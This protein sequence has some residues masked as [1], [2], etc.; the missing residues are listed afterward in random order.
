M[1]REQALQLA[2][3][4]AQRRRRLCQRRRL[5]DRA[6]QQVDRRQHRRIPRPVA[7]HRRHLLRCLGVADALVDQLVGDVEGEAAAV[8]GGDRGQ[9]QVDAGGAAG[10]GGDAAGALEQGAAGLDLAVELGEG[11]DALPVQGDGAA[12]EQAGLGQQEGAGVDGPE[13]GT[14]GCP[15]GAASAAR[16]GRPRPWARSWCRR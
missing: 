14:C 1:G 9:R 15:G 13:L 11:G 10:A 2:R 4:H 6:L 8:L 16:R 5:L 7:A 12:G 3:R